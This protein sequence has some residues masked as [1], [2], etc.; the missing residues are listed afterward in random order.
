MKVLSGIPFPTLVVKEN[1]SVELSFKR[2]AKPFSTVYDERPFNSR[3]K[4]L[5]TLMEMYERMRVES[6]S[7]P[8]KDMQ[9]LT[10][11]DAKLIEAFQ[12]VQHSYNTPKIDVAHA[13][14]IERGERLIEKIK[15]KFP[16]KKQGFVISHS[17]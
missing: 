5:D 10:T 8:K 6:V 7:F 16:L 14:F 9:T 12:L 1:G 2:A 11:L 3:M 15:D 4:I 13:L 17:G